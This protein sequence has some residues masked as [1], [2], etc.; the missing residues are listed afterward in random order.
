VAVF[1]QVLVSHK[2]SVPARD[3]EYILQ[4]EG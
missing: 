1:L 4:N 3:R 2:F